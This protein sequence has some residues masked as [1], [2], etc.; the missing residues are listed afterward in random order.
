MIKIFYIMIIFEVCWV[1]FSRYLDDLSLVLHFLMFDLL[2]FLRSSCIASPLA[3]YQVGTLD[4]STGISSE[5]D[6]S[7]WSVLAGS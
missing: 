2:W 1:I 7:G 4:L 6:R 5:E 3:G